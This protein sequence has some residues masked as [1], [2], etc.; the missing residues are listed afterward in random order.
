MDH[1]IPL[2]RIAQPPGPHPFHMPND[3]DLLTLVSMRVSNMNTTCL[4]LGLTL[5]FSPC[6][7]DLD[8]QKGH[9]VRARELQ[10]DCSEWHPFQ[11][12]CQPAAFLDPRLV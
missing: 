10:D 11:T 8:S 12:V 3:D 9:C 4:L 1:L 7:V 6:Q 5:S 2:G